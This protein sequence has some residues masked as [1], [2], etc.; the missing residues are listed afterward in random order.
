[1]Q[2]KVIDEQGTA[3]PSVSALQPSPA[4]S[5]S[6]TAPARDERHEKL[7][8]Q[9][10][11]IFAGTG[12]IDSW[13]SETTPETVVERLLA[14]DREPLPR[15]QLNQLL[16]LSHEAGLSAGFFDY[17]WLSAPEHTYD[18]RAVEDFEAGFPEQA[19]LVSLKH[20]RWGL[21]RFYIDAL[22]YFGNI[23]SAYRAL[24]DMKPTE[25]TQFFEF[26]RYD[27]PG[28]AQRGK[29]LEL[30]S[31]TR[32]D[33]FLIAE[34]AY[35]ALHSVGDEPGRLGKILRE[36]FQHHLDLGTSTTIS[37]DQLLSEAPP[38]LQQQ[39]A[40][41][42]EEFLNDELSL[43]DG[44]RTLEEVDAKIERLTRR[45]EEA[46]AAALHNTTLYLSMVEELDV[47]VATSMGKRQDFRDIARFCKAVFD[48]ERVRDLN[49]RYFDPTVSAAAGHQDKGLIECLMVKSAQILIWCAGEEDSYGKDAEA[50][51][52]LSQ[53][54]PVICYCEDRERLHFFR[55]THP[56][57][58]LIDFDTGVANGWMV[59]DSPAK[60]AELL[61]RILRNEMRYELLQPK[62]GYLALKEELT[63]SVVR[64]QTNDELLRETFW[65][66]Y[67]RDHRSS[68]R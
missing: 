61:S 7:Q 62:P 31:I 21:R 54:K 9:F 29:P 4:K 27:A 46:R 12:G 66:Y 67:H 35:S 57:G 1:M 19:A 55:D 25:L 64:L 11:G 60:V 68:M 18:V 40:F 37:V 56:L 44:L 41:A 49:V 47:Y 8:E 16:V 5:P 30:K 50:A 48:D 45:F 6:S 39:L 15:Q 58:R 14:I 65:N 24:R 20:L 53:G 36:R 59:A 34:R 17:Y 13:I 43:E 32:D 42:A 28:R 2:D 51:M 22:L 3:E 63:G 52:A 33:R 38:E 26:H 23:R 10:A